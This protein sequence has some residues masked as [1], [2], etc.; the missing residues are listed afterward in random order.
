MKTPRDEI[1]A[2]FLTGMKSA[3]FLSHKHAIGQAAIDAALII[4][5]YASA[6]SW[7][8]RILVF[9][10]MW[11]LFGLVVQFR[12]IRRERKSSEKV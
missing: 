7:W 1:Q 8:S 11:F 5:A 12:A 6:P 4:I 2:N 3:K 10:A 9:V